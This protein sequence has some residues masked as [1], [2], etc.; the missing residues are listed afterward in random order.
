MCGTG[1]E[2]DPKPACP[3]DLHP[4]KQHHGR[5]AAD[6]AGTA[7]QRPPHGGVQPPTLVLFKP[8]GWTLPVFPLT[9]PS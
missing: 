3:S 7:G 5:C 4:A 2:A 8:Q 6:T 9:Q 1:G